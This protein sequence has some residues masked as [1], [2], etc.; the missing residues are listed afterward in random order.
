MQKEMYTQCKLYKYYK[1]YKFF[2]HANNDVI[3][4]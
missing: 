4:T 3:N 1:E 2:F